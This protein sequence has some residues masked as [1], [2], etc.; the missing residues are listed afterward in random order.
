MTDETKTKLIKAV[1]NYI[2]GIE[3]ASVKYIKM[4]NDSFED[5]IIYGESIIDIENLECIRIGS[6]KYY[7]IMK[8]NE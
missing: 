8:N 1:E 2:G 5:E 6:E 3:Q 4:M 7:E